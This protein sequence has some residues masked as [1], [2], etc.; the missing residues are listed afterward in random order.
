MEIYFG[1]TF[2]AILMV[3]FVI[4]DVTRDKKKN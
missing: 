1:M 4:I 3:V 2:L